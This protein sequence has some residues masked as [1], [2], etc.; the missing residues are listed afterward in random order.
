MYF[1]FL[2]ELFIVLHQHIYYCI[3][4]RFTVFTAHTLNLCDMP[5]EQ[6]MRI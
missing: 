2:T 4:H 1:V 5:N 3:L 6:Y